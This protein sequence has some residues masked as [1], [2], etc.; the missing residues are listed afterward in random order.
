MTAFESDHPYVLRD[1][2]RFKSLYCAAQTVLNSNRTET[3]NLFPVRFYGVEYT[4]RD[5][6][7]A[8]N[9]IPEKERT[10]WDVLLDMSRSKP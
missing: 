8:A 7:D 5:L 4:M 3:A 1:G 10:A 6:R 2:R 9:P